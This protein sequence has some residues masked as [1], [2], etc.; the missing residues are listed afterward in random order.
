MANGYREDLTIDRIDNDKGY[1]S[2]NCRWATYKEQ[3]NNTRRKLYNIDGEAHTLK[4][5][6]KILGISI[7]RLYSLHSR[8]DGEEKVRECIAAA[9]NG[10]D[11]RLCKTA[12][13]TEEEREARRKESIRMAQERYRDKKR[14]E[15][16]IC[17]SNGASQQAAE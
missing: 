12:K 17:K 11:Y 5:W 14:K 15:K 16:L 6:G 13:Y 9:K 3:A 2:D 10:E 7:Q 1:Y 4:E 8:S